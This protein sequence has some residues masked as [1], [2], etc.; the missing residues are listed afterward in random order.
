MHLYVAGPLTCVRAAQLDAG[1]QGAMVLQRTALGETA[2]PVGA[3]QSL[4]RT[5]Q[6]VLSW[7][8]RVEHVPHRKVKPI[9]RI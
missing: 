1:H 9:T 5:V 8:R 6:L 2:V 4:P 7:I 3:F